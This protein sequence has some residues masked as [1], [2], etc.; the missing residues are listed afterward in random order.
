MADYN[1]QQRI[2]NSGGTYDHL[3]PVTKS[4]LVSY[5]DTNVKLAIDDVKQQ[6]GSMS[7]L[8]LTQTVFSENTVTETKSDGSILLTTFNADNTITEKLTNNGITTTKKIT[9][10]ADGSIKEELI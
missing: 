8:S 3:F 5:G 1:I 9:F 7:G 2:L 4:E 10:N 6:I